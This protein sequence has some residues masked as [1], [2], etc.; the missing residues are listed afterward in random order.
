MITQ[1]P[2][3]FAI[4]RRQVLAGSAALILEIAIPANAQGDKRDTIIVWPELHLLSGATMRPEDWLNTP[5]VVVFWETWCPY[6]KRQ[7]VHIDQ[8][9]RATSS[10]KI[11]IIGVTTETNVAKVKAYMEASQFIFPVAI[12]DSSFRTQFTHRLVVPLTCLVSASG[13]LMQVIPGEMTKEDVLSLAATMQTGGT[14]KI[15]A[16]TEG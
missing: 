6:C 3:S 11:R 10:Q 13:R 14:P 16:I 15:A 8:L 4:S 7:N 12:V 9:Y 2:V 1:L 5:A